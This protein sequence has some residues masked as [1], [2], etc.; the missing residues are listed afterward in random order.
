MSEKVYVPLGINNDLKLILEKGDKY[1]LDNKE[2]NDQIKRIIEELEKELESKEEIKTDYIERELKV[3][4]YN[5][6]FRAGD[7]VFKLIE[8][9]QVGSTVLYSIDD[10]DEQIGIVSLKGTSLNLEGY[11]FDAVEFS[12][13]LFK[14]EE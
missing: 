4:L 2:D 12:S 5:F 13:S 1:I 7:R 11:Y 8:D 3:K 6:Y 14:N 10:H 9:V